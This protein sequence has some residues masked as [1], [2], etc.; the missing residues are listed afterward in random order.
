MFAV[1]IFAQVNIRT[2]NVAT[3]EMGRWIDS[4]AEQTLMD[5]FRSR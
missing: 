5:A 4:T 1:Y 2:S 3:I